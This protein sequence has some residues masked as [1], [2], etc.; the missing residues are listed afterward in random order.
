MYG[1]FIND[2][3]SVLEADILDTQEEYQLQIKAGEREEGDAPDLERVTACT[4]FADASIQIGDRVITLKEILEHFGIDQAEGF[5]RV[6][7]NRSA[8][9]R[10]K[11]Q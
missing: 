7:S 8:V 6:T 11:G 2:T 4:L 10:R 1:N 9:Q 3:R 5:G